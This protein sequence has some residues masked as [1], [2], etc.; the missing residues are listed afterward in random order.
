MA[1]IQAIL[2][3]GVTPQS[4]MMCYCVSVSVPVDF[5]KLH[6][7]LLEQDPKESGAI[8]PVPALPQKYT[9]NKYL[10]TTEMVI[11][12]RKKELQLF[13]DKLLAF[14]KKEANHHSK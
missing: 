11:N 13:L 7:A 14:N 1:H 6:K 3:Y 12:Y 8:S 4:H 5:V 2:R 10:S 9:S